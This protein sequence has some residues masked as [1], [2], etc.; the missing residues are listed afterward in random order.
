[1]RKRCRAVLYRRPLI[2]GTLA[3][4]LITT[5]LG[6]DLA[7]Q[8]FA[9]PPSF[10]VLSGF[11]GPFSPASDGTHVWIANQNDSVTEL[12]AVTGAQI[13][14]LS[15]PSYHFGF[16]AGTDE[17]DA[18]SDD[19][20]HVW[21]ANPGTNSV[22]ELDASTGALVQVLS[23][24]G[25]G[26][27]DPFGVSSDGTHVW[28]TNQGN[29]QGGSQASGGWVTELD[30]STGA[31]VQVL[32]DASYGFV[33]PT[34]ITSD[35]THVWVQNNT[36]WVGTGWTP[37]TV[38][39]L[40]ADTGAL[41]QIISGYLFFN[42]SSDGTHLWGVA[43]GQVTEFDASTGAVVQTISLPEIGWATDIS[44]DGTDVWVAGTGN[45]EVTELQRV[46]RRRGAGLHRHCLRFRLGLRDRIRRRQRVGDE[47]GREH[48]HRPEH[49]PTGAAHRLQLAGTGERA[50]W[51]GITPSRRQAARR[52]TPSR[53]PSTRRPPRSARSRVRR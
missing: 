47:H 44:S 42:F 16:G 13:Q 10:Q 17:N 19:G 20:V 36:H 6:M 24:P 48:R 9:Q 18:I 12:N 46:H 52:V 45:N 29:G 50:W 28:V 11:S 22:T 14:V 43:P 33:L 51:A 3:L 7:G 38:T 27:V 26:F 31:L 34:A 8:S 4:A 5:G 23:G 25:Y 53:S 21:V 32:S 15:G 2:A 49:R 39:E 30:A 1:M 41:A 35:G 40:D 37:F